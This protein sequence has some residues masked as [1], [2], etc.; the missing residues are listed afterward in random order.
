MD[1]LILYNKYKIRN[2]F[3]NVN[4]PNLDH[5][6]KVH[7]ALLFHKRYLKRRSL[8]KAYKVHNPNIPWQCETLNTLPHVWHYCPN[9]CTT[10]EKAQYCSKPWSSNTIIK[11]IELYSSTKDTLREEVCSR[12]TKPTTH[13]YLGTVEFL[14][15]FSI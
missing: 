5:F 11:F 12:L 4:Q 6:N 2:N 13:L 15:H 8:L 7:W 9:T 1:F 3:Q 14:T 10:G